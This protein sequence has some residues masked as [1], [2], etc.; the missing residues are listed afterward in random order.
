MSTTTQTTDSTFAT[1]I[2]EVLGTEDTPE[3]WD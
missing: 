3:F 1:I 2:R